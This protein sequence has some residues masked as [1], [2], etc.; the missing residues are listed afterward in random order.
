M[1]AFFALLC[2]YI[3][4]SFQS[5][6]I[7]PLPSLKFS[8]KLPACQGCPRKRAFILP[9]IWRLFYATAVIYRQR[10]FQA[11]SGFAPS[12]CAFIFA[13]PHSENFLLSFHIDSDRDIYSLFNYLSFTSDVEVYG[14]HKYNRI[15]FFKRS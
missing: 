5:P 7:C 12:L 10:I 2:T 4:Y 6:R 9:L 14:I 13:N 8:I 11:V 1:H 15:D 3:F